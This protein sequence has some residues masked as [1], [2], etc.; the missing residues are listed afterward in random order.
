MGPNNMNERGAGLDQ[1]IGGAG[2]RYSRF[3]YIVSADTHP[4]DRQAHAIPTGVE[5]APGL[6]D[7]FIW[8]LRSGGREGWYEVAVL[9]AQQFVYGHIQG[10]ADDI[11]ECDIDGGHRGSYGAAAFEILAAVHFLPQRATLHRVSADQPWSEVFD[12]TGYG[13][14]APG[15]TGLTPA[16]DAGVGFDFDQQLVTMADPDREGLDICDLHG[17]DIPC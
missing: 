8:L 10:L 6:F 2:N 15:K 1:P 11:V 4:F 16:I 3:E 7:H 13:Q 12:D 9:A 14:L 5:D 17:C